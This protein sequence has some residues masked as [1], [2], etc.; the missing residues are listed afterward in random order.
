[1]IKPNARGN[2]ISENH[3]SE[4][5]A[6]G[7]DAPF[8]EIKPAPTDFTASGMSA[9]VHDLRNVVAPIRNAIQ[10]LRLR[11]GA[12][13]ELATITDLIER[14]VGELVRLAN[15]LSPGK[16]AGRLHARNGNSNVQSI[17]ATRRILIADDNAALRESLS[18]VLREAGHDVK[19]A[20]DGVQAVAT[21]REW[22]PHFVL[23]DI[24]MP[25][26][27]GFDAARELRASFPA[28]AMR[29]ILMSGNALDEA[30]I[31]GAER[32][33][34]DHCIDKIHDF[35]SLDELL[36]TEVELTASQQVQS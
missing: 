25:H 23:L 9:L 5:A 36:Q 18:G 27:N 1:M 8:N 35:A 29:L 15:E 11:S 12:D 22:Q 32:A 7:G 13:Q 17:P 16:G 19:T 24:N 33:G 34:F 4:P 10:L 3:S 20:A 2:D 31:R 14:Q 30:T 21:G 6:D 28:R 26:M